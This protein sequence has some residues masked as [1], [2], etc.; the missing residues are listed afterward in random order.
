MDG[1]FQPGFLCYG[2]P[3]GT[4]LYVTHMLEQKVEELAAK[5]QQSCKVLGTERQALWTTLRQS[6]SQTLDYWMSLVHPTQIEAAANR[7]DEVLWSVLE[8]AVGSHIP[9]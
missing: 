6:L 8:V 9:R 4:D 2:V 7:M 5:A 3:V 1:N